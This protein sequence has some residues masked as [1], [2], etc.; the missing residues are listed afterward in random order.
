M[1]FDKAYI[2]GIPKLTP[3]RLEKCFNKF[4]EQNISVELWEGINGIEVD[5]QKYKKLKYLSNDFKLKM[6]GS[7]GCLL[8]HV[9]LWEKIYKDPN[10]KVALIC[11]D[12]ILLHKNFKEKLNQIP[13]SDVPKNWDI[14]KLSYHGLDGI[15]I[16][17]NF[18]KPNNIPKR[19]SNSGTFCYLMKAS[20]A[21]V[22][23]KVLLPYNGKS[24]MDVILRRNFKNF[25]PYLISNRIA[26]EL[27]YKHSIRKE[28]NYTNKNL[29]W[30]EKLYLKISKTFF[31]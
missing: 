17:E 13:W 18:F 1:H 12:D 27:R 29:K 19:G 4:L 9:S 10:C 23:K 2:I 31:S 8:S 21:K 22:L 24:S 20:S 15:K 5:I 14:I 3:L 7:L 26:T 16:S 6:P 28:L 25:N 30:Y 11:E